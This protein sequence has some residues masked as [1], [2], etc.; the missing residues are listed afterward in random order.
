MRAL[1]AKRV[2]LEASQRPLDR[3]HASRVLW[4]D[5]SRLSETTRAWNANRGAM[6][7]RQAEETACLAPWA[8]QRERQAL[9]H[10][11]TVIREP[12]KTSWPSPCVRLVR[13][14][15]LQIRQR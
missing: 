13:L 10:V 7:P 4:G 8:Q 9:L 3:N 6:Q 5:T 1:L 11:V 2:R 12:S 14:G 15:A